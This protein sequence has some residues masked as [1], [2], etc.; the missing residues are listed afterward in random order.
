[1]VTV[2]FIASKYFLNKDLSLRN[3]SQERN[4]DWDSLDKILGNDKP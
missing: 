4:W 2:K 1:M 3:S